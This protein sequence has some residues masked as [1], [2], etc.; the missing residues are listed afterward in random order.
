M[1]NRST[2]R[3]RQACLLGKRLR[4]IDLVCISAC[5]GHA[6]VWH[7]RIRT[8]LRNRR[9]TIPER[10]TA[11]LAQ[12]HEMIAVGRST[13]DYPIDV[14]DFLVVKSLYRTVGE[15][16]AVVSCAGDAT[17]VHLAEIHQETFMAGLRQKRRHRDAAR[18]AHQRGQ[19][20]HAGSLCVALPCIVS[21]PQTSAFQ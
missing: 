16:D 20:G 1:P 10:N 9:E 14:K 8:A 17:C 12:R 2:L 6:L 4:L 18:I 19:F 11:L 7:A 15:F 3:G 13:G 5:R 21:R